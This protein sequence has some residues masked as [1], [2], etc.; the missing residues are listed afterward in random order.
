MFL[1]RP[2]QKYIRRNA[3]VSIKLRPH[4]ISAGLFIIF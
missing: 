2:G 1:I 4:F 3:T